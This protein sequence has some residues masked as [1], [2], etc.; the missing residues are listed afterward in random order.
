MNSNLYKY[1]GVYGNMP[2]S[3]GEKIAIGAA[4]GAIAVIITVMLN[5]VGPQW[6]QATLAAIVPSAVGMFLFNMAAAT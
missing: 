1:Q 2:V 3:V 5:G 4:I 6:M